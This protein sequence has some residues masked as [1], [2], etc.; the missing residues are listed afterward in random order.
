[1]TTTAVESA[2]AV[3]AVN[4]HYLEHLVASAAAHQ[5]EVTED[6]ISGSGVKL[7]AKGTQVDGCIH[8]RLL[9]HKLSRPLEDCLGMADGVSSEQ[10]AA[11]AEQ[12]MDKHPLLR[13]LASH[14]RALPVEQSLAKLKLS[15]PVRSLLTVYADQPGGRLSHAVGVALIAKAL[16]RR[17]LPGDVDAHRVLGL[18][19]L[20]HDVGELYLAP[21]VLS[22]EGPLTAEKWR[23]IVSHPVIGQRVLAGMEGA[24]PQLAELVLCHH[25]RLDGFGYPRGLAGRDFSLS[26]QILASAEW[27]MGLVDAG[28]LPITQSSVASKLIPGE[29]SEQIFGAL[30]QA[31]RDCEGPDHVLDQDRGLADALPRALRVAELLARFRSSRAQ[32]RARAIGASP[33]LRSLLDLCL[34]RMLQLQSAFSSAGLDADHP[35]ALVQELVAEEGEVHLEVLALLR[36]FHWRMKELERE[37]QLRSAALSES[38]RLMVADLIA[39]VK[40]GALA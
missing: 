13:A 11:A 29:F 26:A 25:E 5:V 18:A 28:S 21:A 23:H 38:D 3:G 39:A 10:I 12:L 31:A 2:D 30:R 27:L 16:G 20:L 34:Q 19:G 14:E 7:L 15:G 6:I 36:E 22:R 33:D 8:E 9:A 4:P 24:G 40:D 37:L 17:L 1:M 35:E 32:L